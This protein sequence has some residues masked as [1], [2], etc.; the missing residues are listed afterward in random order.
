MQFI[1]LNRAL[2]SRAKHLPSSSTSA[3]KI[4]PQHVEYKIRDRK[5]N[6]NPNNTIIK[7]G[8]PYHISANLALAS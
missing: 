7:T 6:G 3:S 4:S 5:P 1:Y 2:V 8:F